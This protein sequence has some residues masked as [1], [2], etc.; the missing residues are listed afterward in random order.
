M[1]RSQLRASALRIVSKFATYGSH[2]LS[3]PSPRFVRL[4]SFV[5]L[6]WHGASVRS[7]LSALR[8]YQ[9]FSLP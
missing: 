5:V 7:V 4:E 6:P 2:L 9:K 1:V 3:E 8:F